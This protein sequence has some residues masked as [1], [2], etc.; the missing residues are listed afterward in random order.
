MNH[1]AVPPELIAVE[2]V[3]SDLGPI[4]ELLGRVLGLEVAQVCRHPV[5]DADLAQVKAGG[6]LINLICPTD[7]GEGSPIV[8]PETRMSQINFL[9]GSLGELHGLRNRCRDAGAAVVDLP[10]QVFYIDSAMTSG[11]LGVDALLVFSANET[12]GS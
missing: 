5:I 11:V 8:D 7:T 2:F 12:P 1:A 9:V 10:D 4:L 6:V 3:V